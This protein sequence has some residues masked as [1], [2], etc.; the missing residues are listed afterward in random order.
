M[1]YSFNYGYLQQF[2]EEH[3]L[4]KKDLLEAL[5]SS[6]YTGISRW[7]DGKTPIHV[8]AMLRLCN[9]YQIPFE[10]FFF[11]ADGESQLT[12]R[13]PM[14]DSQ[15]MPTDGYG[16]GQ[17]AGKS[18]VDTQVTERIITSKAQAQAVAEG[19]KRK[20][21][22]IN[23]QQPH[24]ETMPA[25]EGEALPPVCDIPSSDSPTPLSESEAILRLKLEH[26]QEMMKLEREYRDR[27]DHI[28]RDCQT[29]FD[30]E[31]NRLMDIIE[32]QNAELSKF[33]HSRSSYQGMMVADDMPDPER[34]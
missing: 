4:T 9:Y 14:A 3:K 31:R 25:V 11:D 34:D 7:L 15:T 17:G 8:T 30:A 19:L 20:E 5:G 22:Q 27:E 24:K 10:G 18:I 21:H 16:I 29:N 33:Y 2:R 1:N 23:S 32:R 13:P 28:R 26:A 6:D 12:I